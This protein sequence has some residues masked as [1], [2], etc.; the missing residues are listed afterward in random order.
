MFINQLPNNEQK[1]FDKPN[2]YAGKY[3]MRLIPRER[4]NSF[5]PGDLIGISSKDNFSTSVLH[6][7]HETRPNSF[8]YILWWSTLNNYLR[9]TA[10]VVVLSL[11]VSKFVCLLAALRIFMKYS[12]YVGEDKWNNL[13]CLGLV[14]LN[15]CIQFFSVTVSNIMDIRVDG[16]SWFFGERSDMR[17]GTIWNVPGVLQLIPWFGNRF[18]YFLYRCFYW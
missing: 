14:Y 7:C 13:Q 5:L 10:M 17:E 8:E 12:G 6:V 1:S 11:L 9:R 18:F 16:F 2:N 4:F 3:I 15:P